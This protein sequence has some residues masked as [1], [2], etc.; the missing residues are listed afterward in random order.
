MV[1][2]E[3]SDGRGSAFMRDRDRLAAEEAGRRAVAAPG[4]SLRDCLAL[5]SARIIIRRQRHSYWWQ[6]IDCRGRP[7]ASVRP[8]QVCPLSCMRATSCAKLLKPVSARVKR[9]PTCC[10]GAGGA[11]RVCRPPSQQL[12][13]SHPQRHWGWHPCWEGVREYRLTTLR[14]LRTHTE[15]CMH[16]QQPCPAGCAPERQKEVRQV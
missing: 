11:A 14:G 1:R 6:E 15:S 9:S 7:P 5:A 8:W 2:A 13:P 16:A 4:G 10:Q 3:R 12:H